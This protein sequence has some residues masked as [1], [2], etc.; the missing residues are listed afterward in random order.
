M[1]DKKGYGILIKNKFICS[2][3]KQKF[4]TWNE[5]IRHA[6]LHQVNKNKKNTINTIHR[7]TNPLHEQTRSKYDDMHYD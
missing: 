1:R 2:R 7:Y 6:K 4:N 3:C 5:L